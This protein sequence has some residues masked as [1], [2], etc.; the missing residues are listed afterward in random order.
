MHLPGQHAQG[1]HK[2]ILAS[3]TESLLQ[4]CKQLG[5]IE[6]TLRRSRTF[7]GRWDSEAASK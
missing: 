3:R 5:L 2:R 7:S 4:R 1:E 6:G